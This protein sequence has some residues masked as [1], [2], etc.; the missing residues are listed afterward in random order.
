VISASVRIAAAPEVVFPY[1]TDPEL[2]VTWIGE[3]AELDARAGGNFAV[4]FGSVAARGTY[5]VVE[6]PH[7]VVFTWGVP[8]DETL[9][10]GSSTVEVVL[11]ADGDDTIVDLTHRALP[12]DREASHLEGWERCLAALLDTVRA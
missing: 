11:V 9:P 5:L 2:I 4:D 3:R 1:F 10:P 7:R 8:G 6:P 12:E